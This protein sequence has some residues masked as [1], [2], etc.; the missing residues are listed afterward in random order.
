MQT[1]DRTASPDELLRNLTRSGNNT[2]LMYIDGRWC[3]A[4]D[5]GTRS[6]INPSN[7]ETVAVVA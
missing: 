1:L 5:G 2:L 7:D 4:S 3:D 6:L